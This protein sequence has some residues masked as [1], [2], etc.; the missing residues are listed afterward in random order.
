MAIKTQQPQSKPTVKKANTSK[1]FDS[2][3]LEALK[4]HQS[5]TDQLIV[6]LG[7]IS[8]QKYQLE[9]SEQNLRQE[10]LKIREEEQ[11]LANNFTSKYGKGTLDLNS[12]TFT[13]QD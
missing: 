4:S 10:M 9:E 7:Q 5:K 11:K 8:L 3:D 12:G 6:Q 13:P 2:K 1:N